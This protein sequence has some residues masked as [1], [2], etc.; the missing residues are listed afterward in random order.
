MYGMH[1]TV[2]TDD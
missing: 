2:Q 1:R